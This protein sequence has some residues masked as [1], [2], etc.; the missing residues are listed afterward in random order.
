MRKTDPNLVIGIGYLLVVVMG[1]E[2]VLKNNT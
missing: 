2:E 1:L